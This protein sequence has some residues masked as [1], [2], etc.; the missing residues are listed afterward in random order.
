MRVW[1]RPS[2]FSPT[3]RAA[4]ERAELGHSSRVHPYRSHIIFYRLDGADTFIQRIR[5]G[6]EDWLP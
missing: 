1:N 6:S 5:H 4:P 2:C 3:S